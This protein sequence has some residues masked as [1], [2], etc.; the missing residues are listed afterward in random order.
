MRELLKQQDLLLRMFDESPF[1]I[2]LFTDG[3]MIDGNWNAMKELLGYEY[4]EGDWQSPLQFAPPIQENGE[5]TI[6]AS[7]R[8]GEEARKYGRTVNLYNMK[9][10][11]GEIIP[12][13]ITLVHLPK[14]GKNYYASY[15][16]DLRGQRHAEE[17][18]KTAM[19][20]AARAAADA[21]AATQTKSEFL[22][23]MSHEIR[24]PINAVVGIT[25][26]MLRH[27]ELPPDIRN[28][29]FTLRNEGKKLI[30]IINDVLDFSKI[31]FGKF[32]LIKK[33]Y[34][35]ARLLHDIISVVPRRGS[36]WGAG[37]KYSLDFKVNIAPDLPSGLYGDMVRVNQVVINLLSNAVKYT[38]EGRVTLSVEGRRIGKQ[39]ELYFRVKD[40]GIGIR[41]ED[42]AKLFDEFQRIDTETNQNVTGS[43]L[44]LPIS[45]LLCQEMGGELTVESV[46]GKGSE[47]TAKIVQDITDDS[48]LSMEFCCGDNDDDWSAQQECPFTAP[49]ARI[50]I[51]DDSKTSLRVAGGFVSAYG[52]HI[53]TVDNGADAVRMTSLSW[54]ED[55][56]YDLILM[57]HMMPGIDGVEAMHQIRSLAGGA[58]KADYFSGLPIVVLTANAMAGQREMFLAQGFTD[59]LSKPIILSD[60]DKALRKWI[61]EEK[62]QH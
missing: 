29:M 11:S 48:P 42:R 3:E 35:L 62:Q 61:P 46:Y 2:S 36:A 4:R 6:E 17:K 7:I 52:A 24:T 28:D 55:A 30:R 13:E 31:A 60:L 37:G 14:D 49:E 58:D 22:A 25:Q 50:L 45:S 10:K 53:D 51:V 39:L 44:G 38:R 54:D 33:P 26:L 34:R 41:E 9:S 21:K 16:R 47:F 27:P 40:T 19:E 15:I 57:D 20:E 32:E 18:L 23:R 59:Y 8:H 5:G 43:G 56:P 12:V 1:L